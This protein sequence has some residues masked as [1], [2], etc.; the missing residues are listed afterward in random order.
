M[1]SSLLTSLSSL[2]LVLSPVLL[3]LSNVDPASAEATDASAPVQCVVTPAA[4][5]HANF[6]GRNDSIAHLAEKTA[7]QVVEER[8][9]WNKIAF[10]DGDFVQLGW[11]IDR[12][13]ADCE[14]SNP[15]SDAG[16]RAQLVH[17]AADVPHEPPA[18]GSYRVHLMDLGTGLGVLVQG[19]DFN[20][21]FDA[22]SGDGAEQA[23][24]AVDSR[25]VAYLTAALGPS[26]GADCVPA[27]DTFP[28]SESH[29][30]RKLQHVFL[31]HPHNDHGSQLD[32]VLHCFEVENF[33]DTGVINDTVFYNEVLN[34]VREEPDLHYHTVAAI[35]NDKIKPFTK[36][37]GNVDLS[38]VEW[39]TF[40]AGMQR[41]LGKGNASF[42]VLFTDGTKHPDPNQNSLVIRVE[43]GEITLLLTGDAESGKR[44]SPSAPVGDIEAQ[45]LTHRQ[46][47]DA[48]IL[49]VGH[50]GSETSSRLEFLR[51]V[52]PSWALIGAGPQLFHDV[53]LPD[54]SV[55]RALDDVIHAPD[56]GA[57][58]VLRTD[59]HD[60]DATGG[61]PAS[62]R[63]GRDASSRPG[64]CDNWILH[65]NE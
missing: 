59:T 57:P 11:L 44:L 61:C 13:I 45:L 28:A 5:V 42:K 51:A 8:D 6:K 22:G 31:S 14:A 33:W 64:G 18:A 43:L 3:G 20:L 56:E 29:A 27:G 53:K 35:P 40:K 9:N 4:P 50:H 60:V 52:S 37:T 12:H 25:A 34:A 38:G 7:V 39:T 16:I 17:R 36:G 65:I 63:V 48:D 49:Q 19:S 62:D 30:Q 15:P 2:G 47:I 54:E 46:D 32:N 21:L 41:K 10:I 55:I 26:G 58:R 24:S 1:R 23:S